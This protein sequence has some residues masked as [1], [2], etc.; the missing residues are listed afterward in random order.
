M[1]ARAALQG[2][3]AALAFSILNAMADGFRDIAPRLPSYVR[4][5]LWKLLRN[6]GLRQQ[7][8]ALGLAEQMLSEG[9]DGLPEDAPTRIKAGA[10]SNLVMLRAIRRGNTPSKDVLRTIAQSHTLTDDPVLWATAQLNLADALFA[11][12][13]MGEA[14]QSYAAALRVF[15]LDN[16]PIEWARVQTKLGE[17][18]HSEA[19]FADAVAIY[20]KA[21]DVFSDMA[22]RTEW[23]SVQVKLGAAL[24]ALGR[25][26]EG[27]EGAWTLVQA[28]EAY[29]NALEVHREDSV[30][31]Q[32][33]L[34]REQLA[35]AELALA[36]HSA[37]PIAYPHLRASLQHLDVVL[38]VC[39]AGFAEDRREEVTA[40]RKE[41]EDR[42]GGP[43]EGLGATTRQVP[44]VASFAHS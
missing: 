44:N 38:S 22:D 43:G 30:P 4:T 29:R 18:I 23:S 35:R 1:R 34:I 3:D 25:D 41:V 10:E 8:A 42:L 11:R 31:T 21:A 6:Y 7:P 27:D 9:L 36:E 13:Q 14:T 26:Q 39:K 24:L 17:I 20:R 15:T 28:G 16:H 33:A 12:Q 37:T 5:E 2:D 32:W 19:Q 40:L